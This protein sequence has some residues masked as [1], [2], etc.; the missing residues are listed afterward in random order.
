MPKPEARLGPEA[1][2]AEEILAG[3]TERTDAAPNEPYEND[4]FVLPSSFL[5]P[6]PVST[7]IR[8]GSAGANE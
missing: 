4:S 5:R 8:H 6:V 1:L 2:A 7:D 3:I